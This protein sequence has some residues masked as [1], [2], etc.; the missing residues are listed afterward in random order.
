MNQT[1]TPPGPTAAEVCERLKAIQEREESFLDGYD[2]DDNLA[3]AKNRIQT[4]SEAIA[5]LR[6]T[7]KLKVTCA[8]FQS[9]LEQANQ[10]R[11]DALNVAINTCG[12]LLRVR[13]SWDD[14]AHAITRITPLL[15]DDDILVKGSTVAEHRLLL[16]QRDVIVESLPTRGNAYTAAL[17][18]LE[19]GEQERERL[20]DGIASWKA[21]AFAW[22]RQAKCEAK[23]LAATTE[24]TYPLPFDRYTYPAL[25]DY[26]IALFK[27]L[28][29]A[30]E[31]AVCHT[32]HQPNDQLCCPA[33]IEKAVKDTLA[34]S[35]RQL[36]E[37]DQKVQALRREVVAQA[38]IAEEMRK[39]WVKAEE[40]NAAATERVKQLEV[41][42]LDE[43]EDCARH[44]CWT[45]TENSEYQGKPQGLVTDSG[46]TSTNAHNLRQ[47][48]EAGRFR[49]IREYGRMVVGYWPENDPDLAARTQAAQEDK[50]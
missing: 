44:A 13:K 47:L 16:K 25:Y 39:T 40:K 5:A 45:E 19:Q 33:C 34:D 2:F 48:A 9:L 29:E 7:E 35:E 24:H 8:A 26:A 14:L 49:I 17:T 36:A 37:A 27:E 20:E 38:N 10:E 41:E 28:A 46:A 43:I 22:E 18:L 3:R 32:C 15:S 11:N 30:N 12:D 6:E 50:L 31:H 4:L 21:D 23:K 42:K 1:P